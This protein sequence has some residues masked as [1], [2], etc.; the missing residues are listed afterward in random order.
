MWS[1][2]FH[3]PDVIVT[4]DD[5]ESARRGFRAKVYS[6]GIICMSALHWFLILVTG[7]VSAA[8]WLRW[9]FTLRTLLIAMTVAAIG[10]G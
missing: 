9:R 1:P 5:G 10:L 4:G 6:D 3:P 2:S 7:A 8:S